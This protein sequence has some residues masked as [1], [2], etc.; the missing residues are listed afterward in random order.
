MYPMAIVALRSSSGII[1]SRKIGDRFKC[2]LSGSGCFVRGDSVLRWDDVPESAACVGVSAGQFGSA[3]KFKRWHVGTTP[4]WT[5]SSGAIAD[6]PRSRPWSVE[7]SGVECPHPAPLR[8]SGAQ[9]GITPDP[10]QELPRSALNPEGAKTQSKSD[11]PLAVDE[12]L[13]TDALPAASLS[14]SPDTQLMLVSYPPNLEVTAAPS[15]AFTTSSWPRSGFEMVSR[16][17]ALVRHSSPRFGLAGAHFAVSQAA[18]F[19][20]RKEMAEQFTLHLLGQDIRDANLA[21]RLALDLR[22]RR[23]KL[24]G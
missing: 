23:R 22:R 3:P 19:Q 13:K 5:L 6:S 16:P 24:P 14:S 18:T 12:G 4:L 11:A 2:E 20:T 17:T 7:P 1:G 9:Q 15:A 21:E 8:E 10:T